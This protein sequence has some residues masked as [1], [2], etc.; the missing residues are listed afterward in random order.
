MTPLVPPL[1]PPA[2]LVSAAAAFLSPGECRRAL[3]EAQEP[4]QEPQHTP[5]S[6]C[7]AFLVMRTR[8]SS[9]PLCR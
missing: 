5:C 6:P 1:V 7:L 8:H 3:G 9:G 2:G 4:P